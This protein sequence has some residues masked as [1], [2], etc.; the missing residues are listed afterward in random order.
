MIYDRITRILHGLLAL[1]ILSQLLT[2]LIMVTP[3]PGRSPNEFFEIHETIGTVLLGVLVL[4][5]LWM[6]TSVYKGDPG[7]LFPWFKAER[8]K[9]LIRD[10]QDSIADLLRLRLP[11]ADEPRPLPAAI[12]G[13]G[14]LC[15][16]LLATTGVIW[17]LGAAPDGATGPVIHT[18]KEVHESL[19]SPMW[20]YLIVHAGMGIAHQLAG[21]PIVSRMFLFWR[22]P[23]TNR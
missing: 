8:R 9:A 5:W 12:Q 1:G 15:A 6:L 17:S 7:Q 13:L 10:V 11:H 18:I 20:A 23:T 4:H 2:S 22:D 3:K 14:L 16:T 21:A 19:G